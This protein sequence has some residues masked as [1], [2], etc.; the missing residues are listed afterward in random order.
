V[1]GELI[2]AF[3]AIAWCREKFEVF[4]LCYFLLGADKDQHPNSQIAAKL[5]NVQLLYPTGYFAVL[6]SKL[7]FVNYVHLS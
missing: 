3:Q 1:E 7:V 2:N 5:F 4:R 6:C